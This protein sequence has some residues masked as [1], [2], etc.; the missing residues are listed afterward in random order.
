MVRAQRLQRRGERMAT[1]VSVTR[2][3]SLAL[4][5]LLSAAIFLNYIDRGLLGVAGP[6]MKDE[7]GLSATAF[8]FAVSAF[9]WIYAPMQLLIGWLCDRHCVYRLFAASI[10]LW[11]LSTAL[12]SFV[13]GLAGLL[14]LRVC[15]G[16]GESIAFPGSSKIICPTC[17]GLAA[18]HGERLRSR[19]PECSAR[20]SG[21]SPAG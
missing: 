18:R 14:L 21:R 1:A 11:A 13:G 10:A 20:R 6:L 3:S 19:G 4:V 17:S 12:T 16:I 8:G 5:V 7:L 15:L 9:F 2:V